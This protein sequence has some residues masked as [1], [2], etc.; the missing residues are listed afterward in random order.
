MFVPNPSEWDKMY[1]HWRVGVTTWLMSEFQRQKQFLF[2]ATQSK[3]IP[4][5]APQAVV[6]FTL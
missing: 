5:K 4:E 3:K 6:S 1:Q 2:Y